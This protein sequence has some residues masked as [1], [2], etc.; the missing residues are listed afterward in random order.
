MYF[1][2]TDLNEKEKET[3]KIQNIS[4]S[5]FKK[6]ADLF[7]NLHKENNVTENKLDLKN[8][9]EMKITFPENENN[10]MNYEYIK[11]EIK[12]IVKNMGGKINIKHFFTQI[13]HKDPEVFFVFFIT[14]I[15]KSGNW[16]PYLEEGNNFIGLN[17][18]EI[19]KETFLIYVLLGN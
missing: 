18:K 12:M 7:Y 3:T 9:E 8:L 17:V 2:S 14:S 16:R 1:L 19:S 5:D 15:V 4:Q 10:L 13:N 6:V 11:Q